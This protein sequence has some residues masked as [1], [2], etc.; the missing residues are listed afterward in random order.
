MHYA[1][2][3]V[4]NNYNSGIVT[5]ERTIGLRL[6]VLYIR[7]NFMPSSLN[8]NKAVAQPGVKRMNWEQNFTLGYE[9]YKSGAN[10]LIESCMPTL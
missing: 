10:P 7:G 4:V 8:V 6:L 3:C 2:C 9:N 5:Q 1:T